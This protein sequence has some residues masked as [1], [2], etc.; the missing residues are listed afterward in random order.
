MIK[1]LPLLE[2]RSI[3][4]LK[5]YRGV[6]NGN[7]LHYSCLENPM[8]REAWQAAVH[9]V[10]ESLTQLSIHT[11]FEKLFSPVF[12]ISPSARIGWGP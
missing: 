7:P 9:R 11:K 4:G 8:D 10:A 6:G 2:T 1:N 5:R 3:C 12:H